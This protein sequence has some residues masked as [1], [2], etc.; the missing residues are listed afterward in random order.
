MLFR[1]IDSGGKSGNLVDWRRHLR[2]ELRWQE[3]IKRCEPTLPC[4][5]ELYEVQ[6]VQSN[7]P[8][9]NRTLQPK[10]WQRV[11]TWASWGHLGPSWAVVGHHG[12]DWAILEP[13]WGHL[14]SSWRLPGAIL[15]HLGAILGPSWGHL[16]PSWAILGPSWGHLGPLGWSTWVL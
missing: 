14:G 7:C 15:G 12:P 5:S 11:N 4:S 2:R 1:R 16:G 3:K 6:S 9:E 13:S 10:H 8:F